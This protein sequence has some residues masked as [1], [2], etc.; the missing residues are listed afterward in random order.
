MP[1]FTAVLTSRS[2]KRCAQ[3]H[4]PPTPGAD[5]PEFMSLYQRRSSDPT[6]E[7]RERPSSMPS[8]QGSTSNNTALRSSNG[9]L[10]SSPDGR[11]YKERRPFGESESR[12]RAAISCRA[13]V[14]VCVC[15]YSELLTESRVHDQHVFFGW[16]PRWLR[17][18]KQ[19]GANH[20]DTSRFDVVCVGWDVFVSITFGRNRVLTATQI[21]VNIAWIWLIRLILACFS[22]PLQGLTYYRSCWESMAGQL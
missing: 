11:P 9:V 8:S 2:H 20:I 12:G 16:V 4:S 5:Y 13:F 3:R 22:P 1:L 15:V 17:F 21:Q 7:K 18:W 14:C 19:H 10:P 6:R